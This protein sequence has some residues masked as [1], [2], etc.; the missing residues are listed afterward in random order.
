[1]SNSSQAISAAFP[2]IP[3]MKKTIQNIRHRKNAPPANPTTLNSLMFNLIL[4]EPYTV[5][6]NNEP[7]LLYDNVADDNNRIVLFSTEKTI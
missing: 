7:F 4:F 5:T 3:A 2:S 1:M 6:M